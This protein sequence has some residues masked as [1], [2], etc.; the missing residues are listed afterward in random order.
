[1]WFIQQEFLQILMSIFYQMKEMPI[2][3]HLGGC[4]F[5]SLMLQHINYQTQYPIATCKITNIHINQ[6]VVLQPIQA[7]IQQYILSKMEQYISPY[8]AQIINSNQLSDHLISQQS[9]SSI[10][11]QQHIMHDLISS[12][13]SLSSET[14]FKIR[15]LSL[16]LLYHQFIK[17]TCLLQISLYESIYAIIYRPGGY[18]SHYCRI[19]AS[20]ILS[21]L[22]EQFC[23]NNL[24]IP[25]S[26]LELDLALLALLIC[27]FDLIRTILPC[28]LA[29]F[30]PP[31]VPEM[32]IIYVLYDRIMFKASLSS[33]MIQFKA[34]QI[35]TFEI[36]NSVLTSVMSVLILQGYIN[37]NFYINISVY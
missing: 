8:F 25:T 21:L 10:T 6:S 33:G 2:R 9:A 18:P 24:H 20:S 15:S 13:S 27:Y 1:M 26:I 28:A 35:G 7:W 4:Q 23:K 34:I 19:L 14:L 16:S 30:R 17:I 29:L 36:R 31:K 22:N 3:K 11:S 5:F 32:N 12:L 37:T